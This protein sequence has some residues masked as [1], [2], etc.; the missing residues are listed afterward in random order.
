M[1]VIPMSIACRI[2]SVPDSSAGGPYAKEMPIQPRPSAEVSSSPRRRRGMVVVIRPMY[3][4]GTQRDARPDSPFTARWLRAR[5]AWRAPS[6][7]LFG[8]ANGGAGH[9]HFRAASVG[10]RSG[11]HRDGRALERAESGRRVRAAPQRWLTNLVTA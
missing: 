8:S 1:K 2:A 5:L 7:H 10:A 6:N 3:R 9:G 4:I 11:R